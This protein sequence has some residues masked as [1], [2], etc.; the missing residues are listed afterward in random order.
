MKLKPL[1]SLLMVVILAAGCGKG[2]SG[3]KPSA[4]VEAKLA[5]IRQAGE[6]V[7]LAEVDAWY[8]EP[9]AGENAAP[10]YAEAFAAVTI[11]DFKSPSF[12][13]QNQRAVELLHQAAA[14]TQCRYP[15]DLKAGQKASMAHLPKLKICAQ[16]LALQA[17]SDAAQGRV[18]LAVQREFDDLRL[19][20]SLELEPTAI[21][22]LTRVRAAQ[23]AT[24][25]LEQMLNHGGVS[26]ADLAK[27]Q[28]AFEEMEKGGSEGF[29]RGF[30]GERC[31]IVHLF[32]ASPQ[33]ASDAAAMMGQ[34]IAASFFGTYRKS[35]TN[36][37]DFNFCLDQLSSLVAA[38]KLPF[39]EG[40]DAL[41]QW[42]DQIREAKDKGYVIAGVMLPNFAK[43]LT[44]FASRVGEVRT[45]QTALA[46]ER[47]RL[48]HGMA[49]PASLSAL[50]PQYVAAVPA[51]PFD[52]RP[53]H[54]KKISSKGYIIYSIG[55]NRQDDGG[56]ELKGDMPLRGKYDLVFAVRR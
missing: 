56:I 2:G 41:G 19:V 10:L 34:P 48:A 27:L 51:D 49:L 14:R 11:E 32:G 37:A 15:I 45:G 42:D 54:Y 7:T 30:V 55:P 23:A 4:E 35:S 46:V 47:Y 36:Q 52:G 21:S 17:A 40:L 39:P 29:A 33:E 13:T 28:S 6:P 20:R 8:V 9:P 44:Q 50:V 3:S 26:A 43:T 12:V 1:P 53:I 31:T 38:A 18:D 24:A 25:G 16:L 22:Q 5:A